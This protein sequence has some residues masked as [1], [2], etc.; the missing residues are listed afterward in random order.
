MNILELKEKIKKSNAYDEV[1]IAYVSSTNEVFIE[2]FFSYFFIGIKKRCKLTKLMPNELLG[3]D[4]GSLI[5]DYVVLNFTPDLMIKNSRYLFD[6][7]NIKE[8]ESDLLDQYQAIIDKFDCRK[9]FFI[10]AYEYLFSINSFEKSYYQQ[11]CHTLNSS[12]EYKNLI[13]IESNKIVSALSFD[14]AIS[15]RDYFRANTLYSIEAIE[16]LI[17]QIST[18]IRFDYG[19]RKKVLCL[20]CDNTLWHGVLG[21]LGPESVLAT[22]NEGTYDVFFEAQYAFKKLKDKGALLALVTKNNIADIEEAFS[23]RLDF[24]LNLDDFVSIKANWNQKV[25]SLLELSEELNLGLSSFIFVDDS[26]LECGLVNENLPEVDVI[27]VPKILGE[28][29]IAINQ[30]NNFFPLEALS[31]DKKKTEMYKSEA[32][33]KIQKRKLNFD[34]YINNLNLELSILRDVEKNIKR[35]EQLFQKTNQFNFSVKRYTERDIL[36]MHH[37]NNFE[38]LMYDL[39]DKFGDY[40]IVGA[41]II[42]KNR[43]N[44]KLDSFV[45]SCRALGRNIE[46][47]ILNIICG[48]HSDESDIEATIIKNAK[49]IPAVDFAKNHAAEIVLENDKELII[50]F[51]LSDE[52]L[53]VKINE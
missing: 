45:L 49:N 5:F 24:P 21:E 26:E 27:M 42:D 50:K 36:E 11:L 48:Q 35:A 38:I 34:D 6:K 12:L 7:N 23:Q 14:R 1:K 43:S 2:E 10:E 44:I 31:E 13:K 39:K 37:D 8:I 19:E 4:E 22:K 46:K 53:G 15:L 41:T 3:L 52:N 20:D 30:I 16:C 9:L 17:N 33:R 25:E 40:G 32:Q 51:S 18:H 29:P 28:Y 47:A